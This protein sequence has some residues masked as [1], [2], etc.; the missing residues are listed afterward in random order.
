MRYFKSLD[1]STAS[2]FALHALSEQDISNGGISLLPNGSLEID[3]NEAEETRLE[4]L[5]PAP[6][7][8]KVPMRKARRALRAAG[9]LAMVDQAL[10]SIP[11]PAGDDARDDWEYSSEV[12]RDNPTL[13]ALATALRLTD[14][15]LDQLF[16]TADSYP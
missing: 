7:P 4:N 6:I 12:H 1:Q 16:I 10:A 3:E 8:S 13:Q 5:P 14:E 9:L 11:G 2:G 15:Q